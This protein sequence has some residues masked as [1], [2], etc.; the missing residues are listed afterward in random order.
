MGLEF[1][2]RKDKIL[3]I[4]RDNRTVKVEQLVRIFRVSGI[5]IRRD[6]ERLEREGF[7]VRVYGGAISKE[8][9]NYEFSFQGKLGK[10]KEEK[11]KIGKLAA[12]FIK[13]GEVIFLDTGTTTLYIARELRSRKNLKV[14]TN[15]LYVAYEFSSVQDI[16]LILLGGIFRPKSLDVAGSVTEENLAKFHADKAFLGAD[17]IT[18]SGLMT[19]DIQTANV[20]KTMVKLSKEVIVVTDHTKFGR[21]SFVIYAGLNIVDK[22][23]TDKGLSSK[24]K[25]I[26]KSKGIEVFIT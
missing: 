11:E 10:N 21:N 17:G 9:L 22:I 18:P 23:I 1:N 6:L 15:S 13:E 16:E 8:K 12:T 3:E 26:L 4:L 2:K 7:L 14:I 5:T 24:Y 20:A 19:T 25:K